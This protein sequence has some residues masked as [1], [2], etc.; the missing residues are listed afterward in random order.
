MNSYDLSLELHEI[1]KSK[2]KQLE[3][4]TS[5]ANTPDRHAYYRWAELML[6]AYNEE[7]LEKISEYRRGVYAQIS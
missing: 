1:M 5:A 2:E 4:L 3:N 6:K 7:L